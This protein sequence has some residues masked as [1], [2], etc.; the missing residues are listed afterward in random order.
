MDFVFLDI[1]KA[2]DTT[3]HSSLLYEL[4]EL[5]FST[6]LVKL[7]ASFLTDRK[8]EVLAEGEFCTPRKIA[9]GVPQGSVPAPI[10][11]SLYTDDALA[12]SGTHLALFV[13]DTCIYTPGT[14]NCKL[15]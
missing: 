11:Y 1:E 9:A 15:Q 2:F 6:S 5:E 12:A 7:I 10:L 14:A 8:F 13:D 3:W 4:S